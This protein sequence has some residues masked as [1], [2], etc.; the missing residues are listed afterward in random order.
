MCGCKKISHF[1]LKYSPALT[2]Q[3]HSRE[4]SWKRHAIN[5][6]LQSARAWAWI[7]WAST[8][9]LWWIKDICYDF[10]GIVTKHKFHNILN[11]QPTQAIDVAT[12][13]VYGQLGHIVLLLFC[14]KKKKN[15]KL[16]ISKKKS[17]I[18]KLFLLRLNFTTCSRI[19]ISA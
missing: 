17:N 6:G 2:L 18:F 1:N 3:L 14:N 11:A 15:C 12:E 7:T 10:Y 9:Y 16:V 19:A 13:S 5:H 8:H 4:V